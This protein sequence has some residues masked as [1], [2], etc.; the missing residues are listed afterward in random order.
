MQMEHG[1][2]K[3]AMQVKKD[4]QNNLSKTISSNLYNNKKKE[5]EKAMDFRKDFR[6]LI[7]I[8]AVVAS[9]P[10]VRLNKAIVKGTSGVSK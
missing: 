9:A 5:G 10:I 8:I 2:L 4:L 1:D 3:E 7:E 6:R